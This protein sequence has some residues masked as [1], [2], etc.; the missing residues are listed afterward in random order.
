MWWHNH[1]G[2]LKPYGAVEPYQTYQQGTF[3]THPWSATSFAGSNLP[4]AVDG[5]Q[6]FIGTVQDDK[7]VIVISQE[8][9]DAPASTGGLSGAEL[10]CETS[11]FSQSTCE[12]I[13]CCHWNSGTCWSSVGNNNCDTYWTN[14]VE[15]LPV[16]P[17]EPLPTEPTDPVDKKEPIIDVSV[18]T[19]TDNSTNSMQT[20]AVAAVSLLILI[21]IIVA[22]I[23]V[24]L[25]VMKKKAE[26]TAKP[27]KTA[28]GKSNAGDVEMVIAQPIKAYSPRT[29]AMHGQPVI[30]TTR[31]TNCPVEVV[32]V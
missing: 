15:P 1:D 11:N 7:R 9:G 10:V 5:E 8:E 28:D 22:S 2:D 31:D 27:A 12:S 26:D 17:V 4:F 23:C 21:T 13:G 19:T 24:G 30:P 16:E 14:P 29:N 6:V 3:A 25:L 20:I 18:D 32:D